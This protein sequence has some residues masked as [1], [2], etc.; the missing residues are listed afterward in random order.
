MWAHTEQQSQAGFSSPCI[1]Q[2]RNTKASVFEAGVSNA[3]QKR[4]SKANVFEAKGKSNWTPL[5]RQPSI[6]I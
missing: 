1:S 3:S 4:N 6:F 2:K 5:S